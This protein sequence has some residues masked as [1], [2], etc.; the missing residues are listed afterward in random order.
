MRA[1]ACERA[2]KPAVLNSQDSKIWISIAVDLGAGFRPTSTELVGSPPKV[3]FS[4]LEA[5]VWH[6]SLRYELVVG[7]LRKNP[8][9]CFGLQHKFKFRLSPEIALKLISWADFG[10]N[11]HFRANPVDLEVSRGQV[12]VV[13]NGSLEGSRGGT[14]GDGQFS[15][16][17]KGQLRIG[18]DRVAGAL[19]RPPPPPHFLQEYP[20]PSR[21]S[22]LPKCPTSDP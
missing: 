18:W 8:Y 14:G 13:L 12:S 1:G 3:C 21:S 5:C 2:T 20:V 10:C 6:P 9:Q 11:P 16:V 17:A 4:S 22:R 15:I 7:Q 19:L